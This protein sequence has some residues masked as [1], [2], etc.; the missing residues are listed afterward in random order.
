MKFQNPLIEYIYIL[1]LQKCHTNSSYTIHGLW[2]NYN[3]GGY[4]QFCHNTPFDKDV[5]LP[6]E[7][8]LEKVWLSC[9]GK[10]DEFLWKHE[11]KKHGTCFPKVL[12]EWEYFSKTL[13]IFQKHKKD[14]FNGCNEKNKECLLP[15]KF[16]EIYDD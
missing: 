5:L 15:L 11:F 2:I 16:N 6:I 14:G 13:K 1:S 4:P 7:S 10:K 3:T 8:E 12:T 9:Y